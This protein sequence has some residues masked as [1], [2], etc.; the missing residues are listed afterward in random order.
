MIVLILVLWNLSRKYTSQNEKKAL[1]SQTQEFFYKHY[2]YKHWGSKSGIFKHFLSICWGWGWSSFDVKA[3]YQTPLH[4]IS[5]IYDNNILKRESWKN[6]P[7]VQF[8]T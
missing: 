8:V 4:T 3:F 5:L 2:F 6:A 1:S 7:I